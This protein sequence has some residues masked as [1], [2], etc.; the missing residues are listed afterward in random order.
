LLGASRPDEA[1]PI[2]QR[3]L[4]QKNWILPGI[5][6][7]RAS[8]K[9]KVNDKINCL[10]TDYPERA[11]LPGSPPEAMTRVLVATVFDL[12]A[13]ASQ[14]LNSAFNLLDGRD[15]IVGAYSD[16]RRGET[17]RVSGRAPYRIAFRVDPEHCRIPDD[18]GRCRREVCRGLSFAR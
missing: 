13:N 10:I 1:Q 14:P 17:A 2:W 7:R 12:H 9:I 4:F 16:E 11:G 5:P 18:E 15:R 6:G 3:C 8:R